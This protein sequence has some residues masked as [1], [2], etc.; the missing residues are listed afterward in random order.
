MIFIAYGGILVD[1]FCARGIEAARANGG[2]CMRGRRGLR[3]ITVLIVAVFAAAAGYGVS[4]LNGGSDG[5]SV[6][7]IDVGQADAA[8]VA[9]EGHYM[10]IDGGNAADSDTVYTYLRKNGVDSLDAVICT[11]AHEDH[12]GGLSGALAFAR[13]S[14]AYC[15]VTEGDSKAFDSFVSALDAQGIGIT[16]PEPGDSFMLGSAE[17]EFLGPVE[18]YDDANNSSL[19]VKVS[20]GQTSFLFTGDAEY[21]SETDILEAGFDVSADVLKV[22]HHGSDSSTSY[23]WLRAV[24][25]DYAVISVGKDNSYG[26]PSSEVLD[27]LAD[28]D[29]QVYRTDLQG[30]IVFASDGS[31]LTV[32]T[33]AGEALK[34]TQRAALFGRFYVFM[35]SGRDVCPAFFLLGV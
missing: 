6:H 12:V 23:R 10:M 33:S 17:V 22:G 24:D 1:I 11:H 30:D 34:P 7:F 28:A 18:E 32:D 16:V 8:L 31:E 13:T 2:I 35:H 14:A 29:V 19:V 21:E 20:Y 3:L 9:C 4:V 5:M 25:A 15:S 27:R 26:H